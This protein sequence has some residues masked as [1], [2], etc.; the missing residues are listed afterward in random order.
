M[1]RLHLED[2]LP[3]LGIEDDTVDSDPGVDEFEGEQQAAGDSQEQCILSSYMQ[4]LLRVNKMRKGVVDMRR[5]SA[6]LADD[7]TGLEQSA[8]ALNTGVQSLA[9][10]IQ[11]F[12]H[13]LEVECYLADM[14]KRLVRYGEQIKYVPH[15]YSC[16][17]FPPGTRTIKATASLHA[18]QSSRYRSPGTRLSLS[19]T[20]GLATKRNIS[21]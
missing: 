9:G 14:I 3:V 7:L 8:H 19:D 1:Y 16:R 10:D 20:T 21:V 17:E 12:N 6:L 2:E 15:R 5:K 18:A 11:Q 13:D 4:A